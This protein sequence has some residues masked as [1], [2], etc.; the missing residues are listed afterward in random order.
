MKNFFNSLMGWLLILLIIIYGIGFVQNSIETTR[1]I[2]DVVENG[3]PI[4]REGYIP[5]SKRKVEGVKFVPPGADP[6][7]YI[8]P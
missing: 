2:I 1:N 3:F 8:K 4:F 7:D 6:S 5:P